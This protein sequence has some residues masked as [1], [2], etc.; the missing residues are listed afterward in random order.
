MRSH[1]NA[2]PALFAALLLAA[3]ALHPSPA[4]AFGSSPLFTPRVPV[5][6]FGLPHWFD[7]SRLH[8]STTVSMGT[9]SWGSPGMNAMQVTTLSY[10]FKAPVALSVSVGNAWG[11]NST[12]GSQSFFL[13]GFR[14]AYQPSRSFLVQIQ[15]QDLR[16][17]LQLQ[18]Y[19]FRGPGRWGY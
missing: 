2:L 1:R 4:R 15:Y 18:E 9:S 3:V 19:G 7:P 8:I 11:R 6:A 13:E 12:P 5:S 16:S 10:A 14:L 17:P